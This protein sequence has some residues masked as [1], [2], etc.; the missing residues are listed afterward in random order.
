MSRII[1]VDANRS[2]LGITASMLRE[3]GHAVEVF[4]HAESALA[5]VSRSSVDLVIA[6][7]DLP[8]IGGHTFLRRVRRLTQEPLMAMNQGGDPE[9]E[10]ICLAIGADDVVAKP[11]N[12]IT[13]VAR[14]NALLRRGAMKSGAVHAAMS[15][16]NAVLRIGELFLDAPRLDARWK[17]Q[18]VQ[19]TK[20]EFNLLFSLAERPDVVRSRNQLQDILNAENL[21][22]S[23]R[24][25]DSHV[26]RVRK[27]IRCVDDTFDAIQ[28]VYGL[29]YKFNL[30]KA[31]AFL[32]LVA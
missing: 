16:R 8:R 18:R 24:N 4:V 23:D 5:E 21:N 1:V 9:E 29:G 12:E 15:G 25:I 2:T 22:V 14:V 30:E 27:K 26:K 13:F 7:I 28:T 11:I 31:P 17:G 19:L 20:T 10:A 32:S 3:E 6:D